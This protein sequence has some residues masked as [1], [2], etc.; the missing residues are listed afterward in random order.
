MY[1]VKKKFIQLQMS[2]VEIYCKPEVFAIGCF[3]E[4][5]ILDRRYVTQFLKLR[6]GVK[7]TDYITE[8]EMLFICYAW[9]VPKLDFTNSKIKGVSDR[10]WNTKN[11]GAMAHKLPTIRTSDFMQHLG[12]SDKSART[13]LMQ[14]ASTG[15]VKSYIDEGKAINKSYTKIRYVQ[16]NVPLF[17]SIAYSKDEIGLVFSLVSD[18]KDESKFFQDV[19]SILVKT[20]E[21]SSDK[22]N[23][24]NRYLPSEL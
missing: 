1:K 11:S 15:L 18:R 24:R 9:F 23:I 4:P 22:S 5:S 10:F 8:Q 21:L 16:L 20:L 7:F 3:Y 14:L 6:L 13:R 12:L 17:L 19:H 2:R